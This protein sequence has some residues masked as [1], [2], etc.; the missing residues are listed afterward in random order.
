[1]NLNLSIKQVEKKQYFKL[2]CTKKTMTMRLFLNFKNI[3]LDEFY[4]KCLLNCKY[5]TASLH[6]MRLGKRGE[7]EKARI[8]ALL[9]N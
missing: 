6:F 7:T 9:C 5:T 4:M 1:M 2:Y 3:V 8:A